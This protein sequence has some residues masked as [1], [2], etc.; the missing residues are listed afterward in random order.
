MQFWPR[1]WNLA[2]VSH[3]FST[4]NFSLV[5]YVALCQ[6]FTHFLVLYSVNGKFLRSSNKAHNIHVI[7]TPR[8]TADKIYDHSV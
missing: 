6:K 2:F 8:T 1:F 4:L 5:V 3:I 7:G